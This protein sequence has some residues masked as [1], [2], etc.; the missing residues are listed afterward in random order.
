MKRI[1]KVQKF[2]SVI[3]LLMF[4]GY[5]CS[6]EVY[7][8][9][10]YGGTSSGVV[11]AIQAA[12]LGKSVLLIEPGKHLGGLTSGG[13]GQ[14]DIGNKGAICGIAREFYERVYR[15]YSQDAV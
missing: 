15:Y 6:V 4:N 9:V 14:T 1:K 7:D 2:L 3:S 10:I 5:S 13:L 12:R 8:V 11:A